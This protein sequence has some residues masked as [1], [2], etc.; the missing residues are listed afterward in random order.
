V[1]VTVRLYGGLN[2]YRPPADTPV[3]AFDLEIPE[4][5]TVASV[6]EQL[7]IPATWVRSCFVNGEQAKKDRVLAANDA[8][9]L[10]PPS[11]GGAHLGRGATA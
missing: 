9:V 7:D 6:G 3:G 5:A 10:F 1:R 2:R 11:G 8:V 4:G